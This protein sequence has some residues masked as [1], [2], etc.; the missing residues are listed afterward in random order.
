MSFS[1]A[2][3]DLVE[4]KNVNFNPSKNVKTLMTKCVSYPK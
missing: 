3:K 1:K 2:E 4:N